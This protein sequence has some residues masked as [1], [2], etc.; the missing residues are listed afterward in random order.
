[1]AG[2]KSLP[3]Q[4]PRVGES[5]SDILKRQRKESQDQ[6]AEPETTRLKT[7]I[8]DLLQ[9][10]QYKKTSEI[11]LGHKRT[12]ADIV[13]SDKPVAFDL[14]A[15]IG[16]PS[17]RIENERLL[18]KGFS[19]E[20]ASQAEATRSKHR[21]AL[22]WWSNL[23]KHIGLNDEVLLFNPTNPLQ[24]ALMRN[25]ARV[26]LTRVSEVTVKGAPRTGVAIMG[27]TPRRYLDSVI[28]AH[29]ML[30]IDIAFLSEVGKK[31]TAGF[32]LDIMR[33]HGKRPK[34]HKAG[35]TRALLKDM[36]DIIDAKYGAGN[37]LAPVLKAA[38]MAAFTN[39]L[40]RAEFLRK[41]GAFNPHLHLSRNHVTYF[42]HKWKRISPSSTNL[43]QLREHGG[44]MLFLPPAL[45]NDP[46]CEIWG[47]SP[48]PY[49]IGPCRR[50]K[51][52]AFIDYGWWQI[53]LE[54]A[55]P[56]ICEQQR[57]DT[58]MFVD[59]STGCQMQVRVFDKILMDLLQQASLRR[60]RT[61][62]VTR[63]HPQNLRHPFLPRRRRKR[64]QSS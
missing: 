3:P 32:E 7:S 17:H 20:K 48:T 26:F 6:A 25:I 63:S 22:K 55:S 59:P 14:A 12:L 54:L 5:I 31:W 47:D 38:M 36:F 40:R 35:I 41:S 33:N 1:M 44:Y 27:E 10:E 16:G 64:S 57:K 28:K 9:P 34:K 58:P 45:K 52:T 51:Q 46:R 13:D 11:N 61:A 62:C 50:L 37:M 15:Q 2:Q 24:R 53:E 60:K 43:R 23:C 30:G 21:T 29:K 42:D 4:D 39:E 19:L 56:L 18:S 8:A 49:P